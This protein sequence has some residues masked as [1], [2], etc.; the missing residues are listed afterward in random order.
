MTCYPSFI[1]F[2]KYRIEHD[3]NVI[4]QVRKRQQQREKK[5]IASH[6]Q[7]VILPSIRECY[8]QADSMENK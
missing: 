3:R 5:Y 1:R 7:L 8:T 4:P 2:Y 6:F